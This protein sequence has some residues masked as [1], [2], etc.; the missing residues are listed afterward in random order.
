MTPISRFQPSHIL[1]ERKRAVWKFAGFL[2][3]R[4]FP[5]HVFLLLFYKIQK[6]L[7]G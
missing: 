5:S 3:L 1:P 4:F 2:A 7:S 6:T